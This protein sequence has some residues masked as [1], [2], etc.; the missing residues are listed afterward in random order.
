MPDG[1]A[2][3]I[4]AEAGGDCYSRGRNLSEFQDPSGTL[5][6]VEM[7]LQ[8]NLMFFPNF[9]TVSKPI[10]TNGYT[11]AQCY[12]NPSNIGLCG[13]DGQVPP[14]HFNGWNYTF[15]DGHVKWYLPQNTIGNGTF[16]NPKGM[17]TIA[18]ND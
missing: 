17:W 4:S 14:T 3:P 15:T 7:P 2:G 1:F 5:M 16:S 12:N 9:A 6:I 8:S 10:T 11:P 18:P 13:Q